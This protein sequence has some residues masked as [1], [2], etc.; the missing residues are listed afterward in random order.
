MCRRRWRASS[1]PFPMRN[2]R[3]ER[4]RP[5]FAVLFVAAILL[6]VASAAAQPIQLTPN[7]TPAP[8][9]P[10]SV[11]PPQSLEGGDQIQVSPLAP[12]DMSWTGLLG[13]D[14]GGFP[15]DMWNGANRNFVVAAL[16]QLQPVTSPELTSLARRLL[17]SDAAAPAPAGNADAAAGPKLLAERIDR[18]YALGFVHDGLALIESLPDTVVT[19][20]IDRDRVELRFAAND[21]AGACNDVTAR[22]SR[23]TGAW[24]A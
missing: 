14:K 12:V 5:H 24:W 17:L 13:P 6:N 4:R 22:I 16:P 7:P 19:D 11:A 3:I 15:H 21:T 23:Y 8:A 2:C 9:N 10:S 1:T 18:I 20:P